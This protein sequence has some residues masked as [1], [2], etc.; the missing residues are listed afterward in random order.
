MRPISGIVDDVLASGDDT[1]MTGMKPGTVVIVTGMNSSMQKKFKQF[2]LSRK[3]NAGFTMGLMAKDLSIALQVGRETE[4]PAPLS[5]MCREMVVAAQAMFGSDA[6][7]TEMARL[8][9]RMVGT[10]LGKAK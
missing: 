7:H 5:A 3:F 8:C 9:E 1:R 6:D 2:V 10:E 4:T